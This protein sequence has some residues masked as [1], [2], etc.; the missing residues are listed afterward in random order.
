LTFYVLRLHVLRDKNPLA[1]FDKGT[2]HDTSFMMFPPPF[3]RR[4]L[5][6][7]RGRYPGFVSLVVSWSRGL[8]VYNYMTTWPRDH[9]TIRPTS[10]LRDSA[11]LAPDFPFSAWPFGL[12][13]LYRSVFNFPGHSILQVG[14]VG[15]KPKR[16][17]L[18]SGALDHETSEKP[19]K[20]RNPFAPFAPFRVIRGPNPPLQKT[21]AS[22]H[23]KALDWACRNHTLGWRLIGCVVCFVGV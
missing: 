9:M 13:H 17:N 2:V 19:R 21:P 7:R 1:C 4:F 20:A 22:G 12:G 3:S 15:K 14:Y 8:M 18:R 16:A 6:P 11:G 23:A 10:Q 5:E